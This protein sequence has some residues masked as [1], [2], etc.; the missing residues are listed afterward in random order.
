LKASAVK[1]TKT[2]TVARKATK[3]TK[4]PIAVRATGVKTCENVKA[5]AE[6]LERSSRDLAATIDALHGQMN[7]AMAK[8][9]ELATIQ[10]NHNKVVI[11]TA[12]IDR[13]T[14]TFQRIVAEVL[15]DHL[16]EMLPPLVSLRNE[17][18]R[19]AADPQGDDDFDRRGCD[20]LDHVLKLAGAQAFD[21]RVGEPLDPAIH[22][23]VADVRRDN[24]ADG[25]V[26]EVVQCGFR[27]TR[28]KV[29]TP[30]KVRVNRR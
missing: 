6:S 30:A 17:F 16:S 2:T 9:A 14:A 25:V 1:K 5:S 22:T 27:T 13:A 19:R 12:P 3:T 23:A 11:R 4:K 29:I 8:L 28:G 10:A 20:A 26:A 21:P 18:L 15:D 24:L 7:N